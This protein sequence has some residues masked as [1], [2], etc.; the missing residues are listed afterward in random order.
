[1][2]EDDPT[3]ATLYNYDQ[4][5][6]SNP[7]RRIEESDG[8]PDGLELKEYQNWLTA[9]YASDTHFQGT[10]VTNLFI[11]PDGFNFDNEGAF[12]VYLR[13][14]D[15]VSET[16][17]EITSADFTIEEEQWI[18]IWQPSAQEGK[19]EIIATAGNTQLKA[20]VTLGFGYLE[21]ISFTHGSGG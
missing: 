3:A 11:A 12:R 7:G 18:Q 19:Y 5:Y 10:T 4:N 2:D 8:G 14:Y 15:P 20:L 9:P 13:D 21:V 16:Y 17:T 6:D 1:M